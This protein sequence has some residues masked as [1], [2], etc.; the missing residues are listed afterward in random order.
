MKPQ[1]YTQE[2]LD[3]IRIG[4]GK[5][6]VPDLTR[7]FNKRF[8]Q[9]KTPSQIKSTISRHK[10]KCG[11]PTGSA[12]GERRK[13]TPVKLVFLQEHYPSMDINQ[14]TR[15][16]NEAFG[17]EKTPGQIRSTCKRYK[18]RS[19]RNGC[20]KKGNKPWITGTKGK[21]KP[22]SGTFRKGRVPA[23]IKPIGHER[24]CSKNGYWLVKTN[25][26]NPYTG[27]RGFYRAKHVVIWEEANGPVPEGH[28]L[29]FRDGDQ[30]NCVLENL[31][32]VTRAEHIH[33]TRLGYTEAPE[34]LKPTVA[35]LAKVEIKQFELVKQKED[36][37]NV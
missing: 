15:A 10:F 1:P 16:F 17:E 3:F 14:L 13:Y 19:G 26:V 11:R 5:M 35:L 24:L 28:I 37:Q 9:S 29:R 22:N 18:I 8:S 2:E 34:E 31:M 21:I 12:V 7:A 36:V 20:F 6:R 23:N 33:L 25:E 32:L 27:A 30:T 4:Y